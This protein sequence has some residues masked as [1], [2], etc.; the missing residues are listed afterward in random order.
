MSDLTM[1]VEDAAKRLFEE[2]SPFHSIRAL[3]AGGYDRDLWRRFEDS[4]FGDLLSQV[5]PGS[6]MPSDAAADCANATF[7]LLHAAGYLHAPVPVAETLVAR[8]LAFKAQLDQPT[9]I[10]TSIEGS[11]RATPVSGDAYL[12]TGG[13]RRI[14]WA[15]HANQF[16]VV[17]NL[18][19]IT[20]VGWL[21]RNAEGIVISEGVN[22]AG[23]PRDGVLLENVYVQL[24]TL[25]GPESTNLRAITVAALMSGAAEA[26]CDL[27]LKYT[28]ER[29]QFGKP[30]FEFQAVQH[31]LA[32]LAGEVASA[33]A[34][35]ALAFAFPVAGDWRR[36]AIAKV[37]AGVAA[38]L[39]AGVA[40]QLH[41]AIGITKEYPLQLLTRRLWSWRAEGGADAHWAE[42]LGRQII[43]RGGS[44]L[45]GDLVAIQPEVQDA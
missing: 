37:R 43:S 4:G 3:E 18:E 44:N 15:R 34:A 14:P 13:A 36:V 42:R 40:H 29:I 17:V 1:M 11:F 26:A 24:R 31:Q 22:A 12:L 10:S 5:M 23:E 8:A 20:K 21:A 33:R 39:A 45:W 27:T 9:G 38:S 25:H 32:V 6:D 16:L 41:G 28:V 2:G 35:C 19:G 7:A 30:I